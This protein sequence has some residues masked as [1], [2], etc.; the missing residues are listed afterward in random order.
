MKCPNCMSENVQVHYETEKQ[1]FSG[2]KGFCG[3]VLLG[4]LGLLCGLC[5]KDKVKSEEK[6]WLCNN[7]GSKFTDREGIASEP[8]SNNVFTTNQNETTDFSNIEEENCEPTPA[9]LLLDYSCA[10]FTDCTN[11]LK[12]YSILCTLLN[13]NNTVQDYLRVMDKLSANHSEWATPIIN[14]DLWNKI[15][16][17]Y[18]QYMEADEKAIVYKDSGVF[19]KGESGTLITTQKI[20]TKGKGNV[21]IVKISDLVSLHFVELTLFQSAGCIWYFNGNKKVNIDNMVCTPEEQGMILGLICTMA[22]ECHNDPYKV[23]IIKG[24]W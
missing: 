22:R 10:D 1:G 11:C 18:S 17:T 19:K 24:N 7:C 23:R 3:A 2:G 15:I 8:Q 14:A 4:P 20:I 21:N 9:Q 12:S 16:N 13:G 5:G 6:Y